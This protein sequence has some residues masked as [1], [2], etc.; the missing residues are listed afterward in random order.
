VLFVV[1]LIRAHG[2]AR[3][4]IPPYRFSAPVHAVLTVPKALNGFAVWVSLMIAL[5]VANYAVPIVEL[6][7]ANTSVPAVFYFSR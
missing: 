4:Q 5:T 2:N 3:V 7:T 6:M 1:V